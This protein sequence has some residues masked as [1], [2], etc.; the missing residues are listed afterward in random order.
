MKKTILTLFTVM[1][2]AIIILAGMLSFNLDLNIKVRKQLD[3]IFESYEIEKIDPSVFIV[4]SNRIIEV[5][6][7]KQLYN[8]FLDTG[9][10]YMDLEWI[11][12]EYTTYHVDQAKKQIHIATPEQLIVIHAGGEIYLN[13]E[14]YAEK[15]EWIQIDN[16]N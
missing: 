14:L 13:G 4:D 5:D 12:D 9:K 7:S 11:S 8:R 15:V 1:I 3:R 6:N 2:I 16:K 10:T